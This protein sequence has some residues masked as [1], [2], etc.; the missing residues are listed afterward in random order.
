MCGQQTELFSEAK[1]SE[2][3]APNGCPSNRAKKMGHD[4]FKSGA[5]ESI[6]E[7]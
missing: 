5:D 4:D 6:R 7:C 2:K 1:Y 3:I